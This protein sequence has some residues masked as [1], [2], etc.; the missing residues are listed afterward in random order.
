L[1]GCR[2]S[3]HLSM[4]S[5]PSSKRWIKPEPTR[6]GFFSSA[7][8]CPIL[9]AWRLASRKSAQIL[10]A[11]QISLYNPRFPAFM[12]AGETGNP[13]K[14]KGSPTRESLR[15]RQRVPLHKQDRIRAQVIFWIDHEDFFR[16]GT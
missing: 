3:R 9:C 8:L 16:Q 5:P 13:M 15:R 12:P 10:T 4:S 1:I 14:T 6:L 2:A 11:A 7:F